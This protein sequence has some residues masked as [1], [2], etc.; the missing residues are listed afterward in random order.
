MKIDMRSPVT[1]EI[2]VSW[3]RLEKYEKRGS[4][5]C[6]FWMVWARDLEALFWEIVKDLQ[7]R[8]NFQCLEGPMETIYGIYGIWV[9]REVENGRGKN[10]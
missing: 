9:G 8:K 4:S 3:V 10:Y 1:A 6:C 7:S 2:R 5:I